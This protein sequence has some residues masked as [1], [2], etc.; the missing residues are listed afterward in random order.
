MKSLF[1]IPARGGS[2]RLPHKN[3]K[4]FNGLPLIQYSIAYA[5]FCQADKIIVSTDDIEIANISKNLGSEVIFRPTSLADDFAK[6]STAA[7]HCLNNFNDSKFFPEIF[8]TL[9]PT[10]PLRPESLFLNCMKKFVETRNTII[11]VSRNKYK[12]GEIKK[13]IYKPLSYSLETRSQDLNP[14]FFEN[15][16]IY[17]S[18]P[19]DVI[20]GRLFGDVIESYI[21]EEEYS[22]TDVDNQFDFDLAEFLFNKHKFNFTYLDPYL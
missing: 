6:T 16:L 21:T 17:I 19:T 13:G 18:N 4:L 9:Q 12:L 11:S 15:G 22:F 14:L 5:K 1:F 10:N 7:Q 2:K 20:E 3:I 8:V